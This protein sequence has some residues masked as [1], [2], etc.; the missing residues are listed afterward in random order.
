MKKLRKEQQDAVERGKIL[1]GE[2]VQIESTREV[3]LP[4]GD[5]INGLTSIQ[6]TWPL[7]VHIP[8]IAKV[9]Q[10]ECCII[11]LLLIQFRSKRLESY[12]KSRLHTPGRPAHSS[13]I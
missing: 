9:L 8:D 4:C 3:L 7:G 5:L 13:C 10:F 11:S 6:L 1:G 2:A 12:A